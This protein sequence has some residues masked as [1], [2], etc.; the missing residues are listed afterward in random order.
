MRHEIAFDLD[1]TLNNMAY[2][3]G[4]W[5][6][7]NLDPGFNNQKVTYFS[8]I[9][10]A[11]CGAADSYWKNPDIF[12]NDEIQPLPM[13]KELISN[14]MLLG[15]KIKIITHTPDGQS[16]VAKDLWIARHFPEVHDVVHTCQ[17]H[18]HSKGCIFIDDNAAHVNR[19]VVLN[20]G[21]HGVVFNHQGNYGWAEPLLPNKRLAKV[22]SFSQLGYHINLLEL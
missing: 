8:W 20:T 7:S 16:S 21:C 15:F 13:A 2:T 10:D 22:T 11:Y 5:I 9:H 18:K 3:W 1:M 14:L 12:N 4:D 19:H 17:K 6:K